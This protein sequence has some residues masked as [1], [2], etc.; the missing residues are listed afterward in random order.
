[1]ILNVCI[2]KSINLH[3]QESQA[4][5][6]FLVHQE[7]NLVLLLTVFYYYLSDIS[8]ICNE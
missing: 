1:M 5:F 8:I 7:K 4:L 6:N 3:I 2:D